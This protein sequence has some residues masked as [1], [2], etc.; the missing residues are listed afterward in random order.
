MKELRIHRN[1]QELERAGEL[2]CQKIIN[3]D[4]YKHCTYVLAYF[5]VNH[6]ADIRPV[7]D[8]GLNHGKIVA[9]P[10]VTGERTMEFY[11]VPSLGHLVRG[12]MGL[13]EPGPGL[14]PVD[15][16]STTMG[17]ASKILML[18]PGLAFSRSEVTGRSGSIGR[19]GYG[20]G[21]Y[22]TWLNRFFQ[23]SRHVSAAPE[24]FVTCG[25]AYEFQVV[26][27][28]RLPMDCHDLYLDCL[29]TEI[30]I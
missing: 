16:T 3:W 29:A 13:M 25:V 8:H 6:E 22:D 20:G 23:N 24:Y 26:P 5:P 21:F 4:V 7:L 18:V 11:P 12:T 28:E 14:S 15:L 9:L 10:K 17:E 1:P 2:I 30:E 27:K 19:L